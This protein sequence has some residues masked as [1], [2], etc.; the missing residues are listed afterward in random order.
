MARYLRKATLAGLMGPASTNSG[1]LRDVLRLIA[2][3]SR[4]LFL[5]STPDLVAAAAGRRGIE[6]SLAPAEGLACLED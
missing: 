2:Q 6:A 1:S 5:S 3:Q 4:Y